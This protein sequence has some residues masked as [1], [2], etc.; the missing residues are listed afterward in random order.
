MA[1]RWQSENP[2]AR[3]SGRYG[4][5]GFGIRDV[6]ASREEP[7]RFSKTSRA[8]RLGRFLIDAIFDDTCLGCRE[9]PAGRRLGLCAR[10]H[11]RL[12]PH[13]ERRGRCAG[14][15]RHV[16]HASQCGLCG[17]CLVDPPPWRRLHTLYTYRP[18]FDRVIHAF[19]FERLEQLGDELAAIAFDRYAEDLLGG[20]GGRPGLD[21]VVPVPLPWP[22]RLRRGFNQAEAIAA[23]LAGAL[24][25]PLRHALAR[26]PS[27]PQSL[28]PLRRRGSNLRRSLVV[29]ERLPCASVLLVDDVV[30]SGAT[31]RA[32]TV[33]LLRAG[34][35]EVTALAV[36][37]TPPRP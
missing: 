35:A 24:G 31:L 9:R 36:G 18:P 10:C 14:C 15:A 28:L 3:E 26:R 1:D 20:V 8:T 13:L 19:K 27:P 5:Y 21:A 37:W 16:P 17:A 32:A 2:I 34:A 29:R 30:T 22:R 12:E 11:G 7:P 4:G 33:S 25:L 23:P 6:T